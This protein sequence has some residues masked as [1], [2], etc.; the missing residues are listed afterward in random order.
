MKKAFA[1]L[2]CA[3]GFCVALGGAPQCAAAQNLGGDVQLTVTHSKL[4]D[5][6]APSTCSW[7]GG[8]A[9][10]RYSTS[11]QAHSFDGSNVGIEMTCSSTRSG[12]FTVYL[13]RG[14][15]ADTRVLIG[16]TQFSRNGFTKATWTNVGSGTYHF[17][18]AGANGTT[19]T[20]NDI[21]MYSW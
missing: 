8:S 19:I 5:L 16:S 4:L 9:S 15:K 6:Y 14:T 2:L 18:L 17:V 1:I 7:Y 11:L 21:A 10:F 3:F 13:Y 20:A 12:S